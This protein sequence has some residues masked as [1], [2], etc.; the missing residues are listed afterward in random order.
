[1]VIGIPPLTRGIAA[2]LVPAFRACPAKVE[3]GFAK[4]DM[5]KQRDRAD[6]ISKNG[7]PL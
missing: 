5:L 6:D 7:H 1:V 2:D 3:T 4:K